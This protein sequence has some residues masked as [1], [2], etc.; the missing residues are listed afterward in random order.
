MDRQRQY[1]RAPFAGTVKLYQWDRPHTARAL[2]LSGGGILLSTEAPIG[3]GQMLTL[4]MSLPGCARAFTVLGKVVRTMRG[5]LLRPGGI[6]LRFLDIAAC[7]RQSILDYV[8][9]RAPSPS[10]A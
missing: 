2:E 6:A 7:D 8:A 5:G 9:H 3:E 4:R 1:P 10:L